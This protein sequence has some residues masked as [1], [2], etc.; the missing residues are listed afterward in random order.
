MK[1]RMKCLSYM[2]YIVFFLISQLLS[3]DIGNG[4]AMFVFS[5]KPYTSLSSLCLQHFLTLLLAFDQDKE[6]TDEVL[7]A[8]G[9][10]HTGDIGELTPIG[11][12]KIIDRK[13]DLFKLAQGVHRV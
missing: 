9:W 4:H 7:D 12:L 1:Q 11:S 10:F 3:V 8:D 6:K 13:K 2:A 5:L